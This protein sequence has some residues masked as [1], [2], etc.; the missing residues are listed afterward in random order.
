MLS[1]VPVRAVCPTFLVSCLT[2][3]PLWS[4]IVSSSQRALL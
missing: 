3:I 2:R 4:S 1:T